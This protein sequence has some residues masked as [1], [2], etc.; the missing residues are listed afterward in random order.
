MEYHQERFKDFSLLVFKKDKLV[1]VLPANIENEVLHSH[2][3]LTYGGFVFSYQIK[4]ETV[5]EVLKAILN[6]LKENSIRKI[7]LKLLPKIYLRKP[8]DEIDYLLF[9]LKAKVYRRDVS[10]TLN[11]NNKKII[12]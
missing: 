3:G 2:K 9:I 8:S 11:L 4:F 5:L 12:R 7:K 6:F 1:A 10:M